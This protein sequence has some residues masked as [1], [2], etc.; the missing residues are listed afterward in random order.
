VKLSELNPAENVKL[1][2]FGDSGSGKTCFAS[3]FPGPIHYCDFDL[4]VSS[5]ASFL[6]GKDKLNEITY[7]QYPYAGKEPGVAGRRFNDDMGKL[8]ALAKKG[9]FPYKTLVID[10]LTTMSDRIMEHLMKE[11][12]AVKRNVTRGAQAPALQDYGLF[13]IFMKSFIAELISLPC[14]IVITAHIDI[15]KDETTGAILRV[16]MLTGKLAK[17]LPIYFEEVYMAYVEGEGEKRKYKAQTQADRKFNCRSQ[18]GLPPVIDLSYE[19]L[20]K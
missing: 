15:Q 9:E 2:I 5:V 1:L 12:P 16:P 20:V 14:N 4:K 17:E 19:S 3:T 6:K 18:R 13:R 7:E 8:K 11:N 10:S